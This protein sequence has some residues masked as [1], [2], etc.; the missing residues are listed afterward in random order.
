VT[1]PL[2]ASSQEF[3]SSEKT[4][5]FG[6]WTSQGE[7]GFEGLKQQT[8]TE[9]ASLGRSTPVYLGKYFSSLF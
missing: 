7:V 1:S 4:E 2:N 5:V 6:Q 9:R 3:S 8:P